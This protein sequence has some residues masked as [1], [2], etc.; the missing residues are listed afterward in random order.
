M[1]IVLFLTRLSFEKY[2]LK[3]TVAVG[4]HIFKLKYD[5]ISILKATDTFIGHGAASIIL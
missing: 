5:K 2:V 3:E 4:H 1:L